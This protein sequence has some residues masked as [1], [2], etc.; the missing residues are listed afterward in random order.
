M[1]YISTVVGG[2]R[3]GEPQARPPRPFNYSL[4]LISD[5][6]TWIVSGVSHDDVQGAVHWHIANMITHWKIDSFWVQTPEPEEDPDA[7]VTDEITTVP[8]KI[9]FTKGITGS[10]HVAV[11][12]TIVTA[13]GLDSQTV[14]LEF[15]R[16]ATE[17][18]VPTDDFTWA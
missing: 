1:A 8:K 18:I 10:W 2:L 3:S 5:K 12:D 11:N 7:L 9:E 6:F 15:A 14:K 13:H 4:E 16:L 17:L